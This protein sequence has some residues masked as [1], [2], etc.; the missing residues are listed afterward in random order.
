[1]KF[2]LTWILLFASAELIL[3]AVQFGLKK[4]SFKASARI[5]IIVIK[6]LLG[7][8][9]GALVMAGPVQLRPAQP[10]MFA[11]YA[12]L[13]ADAV[14]DII[15][16][17]ISVISKRERKF[18]VSKI[19]SLIFGILFF[20]YGTVNMQIVKPDYHTYTSGKLNS[21]HK[22]VF[23]ADIHIGSAQPFTVIEKEIE[24]IKAEKPEAIIL[25]GDITD[26]YTT[27][28]EAERLYSLFGSCGIPVYYI[29]GNH[30]RQKHAEYARGQQYTPEE[31]EEIITRNG[32]TVLKDEYI[33]LDDDLLLLGR[34]D[35]SEKELRKEASALINPDENKYLIVADHQ[36][37][38]F[39]NNLVT[40]ADLQLSGHTH[41]GQLF[42]LGEFTGIVSYSKGE[43]K[44]GEAV[45]LL[46]PG[47]SG[48]RVPFRT[49]SHCRYEVITLKP[50]G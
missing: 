41:A 35:R 1:M 27:K 32:I 24:N 11:L 22:I 46:S 31:L 26:D 14:A 33:S 20:I 29:H 49:D 10:I 38:E 15:Y 17:V 30:D 44:S 23:L 12:A 5:V 28:E 34:E 19:I 21:E 3:S 39:K 47:A 43:Y 45:M 36:P 7:I 25:G 18:Y 37:L 6:A 8:G 40:G 16:S 50:A 42:P 2:Y 4:K 48:W 9:L 13:F